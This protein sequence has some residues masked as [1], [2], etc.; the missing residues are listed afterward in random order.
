MGI[1]R[2]D[3]T[4]KMLKEMNQETLKVLM[5]ECAREIVY[6][7]KDSSFS[8]PF[9][10]SKSSLLLREIGVEY[11][12]ERERHCNAFEVWKNALSGG[13]YEFTKEREKRLIAI[14]TIPTWLD[15]MSGCHIVTDN[16]GESEG[17]AEWHC[18]SLECKEEKAENGFS[19]S[20]IGTDE[21]GLAGILIEDMPEIKNNLSF[22]ELKRIA[23]NLHRIADFKRR[24]LDKEVLTS[25]SED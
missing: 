19:F 9:V 23:G 22:K 15:K 14:A 5:S 6:Q 16:F 1:V 18:Y 24:N 17:D 25:V 4:N 13:G 3:R 10:F 11:N 12:H 20:T 21:I 2:N 7:Y 8:F